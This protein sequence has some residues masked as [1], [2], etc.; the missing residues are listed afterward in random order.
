MNIKR[1]TL[2]TNRIDCEAFDRYL[3]EETNL[4]EHWF[5]NR[6]FAEDELEAGSEI[7]FFILDKNYELSPRNLEYIDALNDQNLVPELSPAQLEI[8]STH[9]ILSRPH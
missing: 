4:L 8:N 2:A 5:A 3:L 1:S 9:H 7:E 6:S